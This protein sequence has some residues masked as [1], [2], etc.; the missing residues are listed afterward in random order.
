MAHPF[1]DDVNW[2]QL[3]NKN[4]DALPENMRP[5]K[6]K[7]SIGFFKNW[8]TESRLTEHEIKSIWN[9]FPIDDMKE[10]DLKYDSWSF[11]HENIV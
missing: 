3:Y 6:P 1:F 7:Y 2:E 5:Q 4:T 9:D 11:V 10:A 8:Y